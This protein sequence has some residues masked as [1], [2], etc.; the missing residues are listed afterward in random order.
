MLMLMLVLVFFHSVKKHKVSNRIGKCYRSV[1]IPNYSADKIYFSRLLNRW[2]YSSDY[3]ETCWF[4]ILLK[5]PSII[6]FRGQRSL[7]KVNHHT[8]ATQLSEATT[9]P[10]QL[11]LHGLPLVP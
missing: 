3:S 6:F 7:E 2:L 1:C 11:V 5:A 8:D 10:C 4:T 9:L